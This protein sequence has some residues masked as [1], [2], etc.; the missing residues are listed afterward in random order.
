[1]ETLIPR[2]KI[3]HDINIINLQN[4]LF[5]LKTG[6]LEPHSPD[7]ISIIQLPITYDSD[8][9][10]PAIDKF[11]SEVLQPMHHDVI[12]E[13]I[14]YCMVPDTRIEKSVMFLGKGANGKSVMLSMISTFLGSRNTAAESLH[15]LESDPYSLAEL[16][17]KLANIFPDLASKAIYEN[18]TFKMLSGN[19]HEIR[20]Q[21]K[22]EHPFKFKNTARLIFSANNLPP[23]PNGDYA[24]YRRWIP[25]KFPYTFE[26]DAADKNLINKITTDEEM[27]GLFNKCV[28]RLQ[29]VLNECKYSYDLSTDEVEIMYKINSD[30]IA[31]FVDEM[32]I[33]SDGD[34]LKAVMYKEYVDW[35]GRNGI[36][37]AADNAFARRF[38]KLGYEA[39]R[40]S[41][42]MRQYVWENCA[43]SEV[44]P[45]LE[46]NPSG[47]DFNPDE[48]K[49]LSTNTIVT[50]PSG[51]DSK[52]NHCSII[53]KI[54]KE[55][56]IK[57]SLYVN[58]RANSA[59]LGRIE[60]ETC[61]LQSKECSSTFVNPSKISWTNVSLGKKM[62]YFREICLQ[63]STLG[64]I[65]K[66][67]L[68]VG[69]EQWHEIFTK[70]QESGE[71]MTDGENIRLVGY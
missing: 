15:A 19:E 11:V 56:E 37:Y 31:A 71:I 62:D 57:N 51:F 42:G 70:M 14:G 7:Y 29:K 44:R 66:K 28:S 3:N 59:E 43:V 47:D 54:K 8:A 45:S 17:G 63:C 5:N 50:N 18:S 41:T 32:V 10:C 2:S 30:P 34:T 46:Q 36:E 26:G 69:F 35:C 64:D 67:C 38:R 1:L 65:R 68:A 40:E 61:T 21:R 53:G 39:S 49:S 4:G 58:N 16:Y 60:T 23:A 20:A 13:I 24:Y 6:Q 48:N 55:N 52:K 12:Y 27:S 9:E 22:Y 25:I 33:Y